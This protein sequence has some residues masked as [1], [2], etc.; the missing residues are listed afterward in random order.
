MFSWSY[1][2]LSTE[3]ARLFRLL[4][5][6]PGPDVSPGAAAALAGEPVRR[7]LNELTRASLLTEH[8]PGR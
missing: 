2:S 7:A 6:H 3:A 1:Q 8:A 4:A 5:L